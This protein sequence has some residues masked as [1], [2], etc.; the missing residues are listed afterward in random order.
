MLADALAYSLALAA[1]GRGEFAKATAATFSGLL[2]L[3]LGMVVL[4]DAVRRALVGASPEATLMIA[5]A[6]TALLVN[7]AVLRLLNTQRDDEAH[8]RAGRI[9]TRADLVANLAVIASGIAV[10]LTGNRLF[11][12][13]VGAG[14]GIYVAR[15]AVEI[16]SE[17]RKAREKAQGRS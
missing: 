12:L 17:A 3:A 8:I 7:I 5:V 14:I 10:L 13:L 6:A 16:L 2:L 11:D 9:F 4:V 15:E 1:V